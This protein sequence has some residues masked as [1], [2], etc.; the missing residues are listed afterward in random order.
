VP[1]NADQQIVVLRDGRIRSSAAR[2]PERLLE[3]AAI[4]PSI[5]RSNCLE[6]ELNA[7]ERLPGKEASRKGYDSNSCARWAICGVPGERCFACF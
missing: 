5:I 7:N 6:E 1:N 3:R 4:M 2:M